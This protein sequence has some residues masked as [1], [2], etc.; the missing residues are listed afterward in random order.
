MKYQHLDADT[1]ARIDQDIA[2]RQSDPG[3]QPPDAALLAA[4]EVDHYGHTQLLAAAEAAGD[5]DAVQTHKDAIKTLEKA[6]Y[7]GRKGETP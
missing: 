6:I 4:W 5:D 7:A 3:P 2:A 1:Q